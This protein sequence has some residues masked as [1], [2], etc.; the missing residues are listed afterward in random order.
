MACV[1]ATPAYAQPKPG[2]SSGSSSQQEGEASGSSSSSSPSEYY[3]K[4]EAFNQGLGERPEALDLETP[5]S[6]LETFLIEADQGRFERAAHALDLRE[7]PEG[8]Q[9]SRGARLAELLDELLE[10]KVLINW[11]GITDRPDGLDEFGSTKSPVSGQ[12]RR[13]YRLEMLDLDDRPVAIRMH[14]V[15]PKG[16]DPIWVFSRQTVEHI[17]ELYERYGPTRLERALPPALKREAFWDLQWWELLA[18]PLLLL[19]AMVVGWGTRKLVGRGAG[20][21][22]GGRLSEIIARAKTPLALFAAA[23]V[24]KLFTSN[25]LTFSAAIDTFLDPLLT[26]LVVFTALLAVVRIVDTLLE[27]W[28]RREVGDKKIDDEENSELRRR[29]TNIY[30]ARRVAVLVLIVIGA[31]LLLVQ[32]DIFSALGISILASAGVASVVLGLAAQ[33]FLGN[34]FSSLQ[35][36]IA[37][38]VQLGDSVYYEGDWA[39]VEKIHYTYVVMRT[40]D[41]RRLVV[42]VKYFVSEPFE[43]W[44]K[45]DPRMIK[46]VT[47]TLDHNTDVERLRQQWEKITREEEGVDG[48][49]EVKTLVVGHNEAGMQVRFYCSAKDPTVAWRVHC[50]LRERILAYLRDTKSEWPRDRISV[51]GVSDNEKLPSQQEGIIEG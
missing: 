38:P 6:A 47:L 50:M 28:Q 18:L 12:P 22:P 37:K 30:A 4:A 16:G 2:L 20:S 40:W 49:D 41:L 19:C 29:Y 48:Q 33:T 26:A 5:H 9:A 24:V 36:A 13:S 42:P 43:N 10:R 39:Y 34:V 44:T 21:A 25:V 23:L 45:T 31:A 7:V 51:L 15:K 27:E 3:F 35:I 32:T 17:E 14:R 11:T 1:A 8:E 46:T